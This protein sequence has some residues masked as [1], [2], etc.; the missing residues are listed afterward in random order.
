MF[1]LSVTLYL[2]FIVKCIVNARTDGRLLFKDTLVCVVP[3]PI[4]KISNKHP[5][6]IK[7]LFLVNIIIQPK[8]LKRR[9]FTKASTFNVIKLNLYNIDILQDI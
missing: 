7:G 4:S 5:L 8:N 6:S 9:T 3:F 1:V 2:N